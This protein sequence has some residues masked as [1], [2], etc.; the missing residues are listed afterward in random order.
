M[1]LKF[2]TFYLVTCLDVKDSPWTFVRGQWPLQDTV[3]T[4][5]VKDTAQLI[6]YS[7]QDIQ[8]L[9]KLL[10]G[11]PIPFW[12]QSLEDCEE[13]DV[14]LTLNKNTLRFHR[15]ESVVSSLPQIN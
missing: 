6:Q 7:L 8:E 2:P 10:L 12:E 13:G 11:K 5:P 9:R 4:L 14:P 15:V 3:R 1:E